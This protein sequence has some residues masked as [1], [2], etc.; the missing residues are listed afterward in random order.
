[1]NKKLKLGL[2]LFV[3]GLLGISTLL[4]VTIPLDNVPKEVL[5]KIPQEAFKY[6][7]LVNPSILLLIA[8]IVG[9]LL[10]DKVGLSVPAIS[11]VLNNEKPE[12]KFITQLKY[13]VLLGLLTGILIVVISSVFKPFIPQ[14]FIE[15]GNKIQITPLA[16]FG[17]GGLTEEIL[18]RFGFMTLVVWLVFKITRNLNNST[19]RIGIAAASILFAAGHLPVAF[20]AVKNPEFMLL[21]YILTGNSVAGVFF[22][23][24]YWK[25]G[26]EAA[27]IAHIFAHVAMLLGEQFFNIR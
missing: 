21:A 10:Y 5:D 1:M 7:I 18:M 2:T 12:I 23:W 17:Y 11:A 26:F 6:L 8:V 27:F 4:T 16:R 25:K 13:G 3:I 9:T 24:L 22:G 14:A 15:L 19:Y 20:N